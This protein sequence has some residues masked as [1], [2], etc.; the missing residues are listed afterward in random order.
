MYLC[1]L[2]L[3][4]R[5]ILLIFQ[6]ITGSRPDCKNGQKNVKGLT[7]II[8]TKVFDTFLCTW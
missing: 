7:T 3:N 6:N 5:E 2:G 4:F 1:Y 8:F